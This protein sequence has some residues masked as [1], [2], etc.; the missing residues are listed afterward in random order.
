M[1]RTKMTARRRPHTGPSRTIGYYPNPRQ[2]GSSKE[3]QD[4]DQLGPVVSRAN[5][6]ASITSDLNELP[7]DLIDFVYENSTPPPHKKQKFNH[8]Q[9]LADDDLSA[10]LGGDG[11]PN[12]SYVVV[13]KCVWDIECSSSK[14]SELKTPTT[15][16]F[17]EPWIPFNRV[18]EKAESM[19]IQNE[20]R[21]T[22]FHA[23][24]P[25]NENLRKDVLIALNVFRYAKKWRKEEGKLCT[26]FAVQ[27]IHKNGTDIV[28]LMLA[29]KW[30]TT[31]SPHSAIS[32]PKRT[33]ALN[34]VM[35]TYFPDSNV[36]KGDAWSPQ[37]FY[38]SAHS[39][40]K[41]DPVSDS[42]MV[43][44]IESELYPFQKRTVRWLLKREGY[45][46]SSAS[47]SVVPYTTP[48]PPLPL[49]FISV[50]DVTGRKCY[51]SHLYALVTLDL[52]PFHALERDCLGGI[53][54]EEMGLGKTVEMVALVSL[55][56]RPKTEIAQV[57]DSFTDTHVRQI[58]TTLI[59]AP[60][61]ISQQW[62]SEI[63]KH[64]PHLK[65]VNYQG[66]TASQDMTA[67]ELEDYL[68]SADIVVSTYNVLASEIFF[69][70]LNPEKS[71]RRAPKYPRPKSP[72]MTL[73]FFRVVMDEAQMIENGVSN[74][75][76][77]A[78]M[79]PRVNAW[80]VTGTPVRK[81][82]TDLL[83]LLVFLR[84]EPLAST[85]HIW[86]SFTTT[87][88]HDFRKL[89]STI[90]LR[91]SKMSVR[92]ELKLPPQRRYV[93]TMPFTAI[94]EQHYQG[95]FDEMCEE[96]GLDSQGAPLNDDWE[97]KDYADT[98]RGWLVRLRQAALHPEVG[99]RNRKA[100]GHKDG[101]LR[102]VDQVLDVMIEQTDLTIRTEQR[103]LL[104]KKLK[105]GQLFENSPKVKE[106]LEIWTLAASEAHAIVEENRQLVS[107]ELSRGLSNENSTGKKLK[108]AS[109]D[110][111]EGSSG[112]ETEE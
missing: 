77:V 24:L 95:L 31:N 52:E 5:L 1:G 66:T 20:T 104:A 83:G 30:N 3:N 45:E 76:V 23:R 50:T 54:A 82:V 79:V 60:P 86:S 72:L 37:D 92:D 93:I 62:I 63:N 61:A 74:A 73:Q 44:E 103:V 4:D 67:P 22:I 6:A 13:N 65:V 39:P 64:A 48:E 98:M 70:Q 36:Q 81:D 106:A 16:R 68:A 105:R 97:M 21:R 28:R 7:D 100:L 101:P 102:T 25:E 111:S 27:L 69:T 26:E 46:W 12:L 47:K 18:T 59:I 35:N 56:R 17:V 71:L 55:N 49:S 88:K 42:L 107:E 34:E 14:L 41:I 91:H 85:K 10:F 90:A 53:L 112:D 89:F 11:E 57:Y 87:H 58:A 2:D 29:I 38:Q 19:W 78:R 96:A 40:E 75:A 84:Y 9:T 109:G 99:G 110:D 33:K 94:E 51:V 8:A 15:R 32:G 43:P 80:C 108:F